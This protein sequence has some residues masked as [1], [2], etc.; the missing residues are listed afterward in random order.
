MAQ[1]QT[2]VGTKTA[3]APDNTLDYTEV[4]AINDTVNSNAIDAETRLSTMEGTSTGILS[5]STA[6]LPQTVSQNGTLAYDTDL[7]EL[8]YFKTGGWYKVSDNSFVTNNVPSPW[9]PSDLVTAYWWD[10]SDASTIVE[11]ANAV[12]TWTD[13]NQSAVFFQGNVT[14]QPVTGTQTIN[15]LNVIDFLGD[16]YLQGPVVALTEFTKLVVFVFD[17][18]TFN[19]TLTHASGNFDALWEDTSTNL[20]VFHSGNVLT[21]ATVMT[22]GQTFLGG[23]TKA[24][25]GD[26]ELFIYGNSEGTINAPLGTGGT[27][28]QVG[29]FNGGFFMD[30]KIAEIVLLPSVISL[31]DRQKA[32][33][34]LA[35]KWGFAGNLDAGHP[36]KSAPPAS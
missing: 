20:N 26:T 31:S 11:S 15:G 32:E 12:A 17:V 24:S 23:T 13:K 35:H 19:N 6:N 21:S 1:Q 28:L 8:V 7:N 29:S 10:A 16:D 22:P 2:G 30:G 3:T 18:S 9:D 14:N 4:N 5:Y 36:Y 27:P 34:Y 25:N 33:G